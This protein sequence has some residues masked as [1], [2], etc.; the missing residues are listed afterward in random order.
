MDNKNET[1]N[2]TNNEV[3][4]V[5]SKVETPQV[6]TSA[7]ANVV[8]STPQENSKPQVVDVNNT[9]EV[10]QKKVEVNAQNNGGNGNAN[11][12]P[13]SVKPEKGKKDDKKSGHPVFLVL[14]MIFLFAFVYFL[15][16]ITNYVTNYMNEKNG[17]NELKSGTMT[18]TYSDSTDNIDYNYELTLTYEKNRLKRSRMVTT[19][20]LSDTATDSN[21]LTEREN[22]CEFLRTVL[23]ENDIG[24][25][26]SCSISAAVQ[27]TTQTIDYNTLN[28]D[29]I[30]NNIAEFEGFYPEYELNES[31]TEIGNE[32]E[33][34]G[35]NCERNER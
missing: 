16:E 5:T 27:V 19:N 9:N 23:E 2:S 29:F 3:K 28:M 34:N 11:T 20:R 24:M 30:T 25:T 8:N 32:L 12:V 31:V 7:S 4:E 6:I 33:S 21:V 18:C 1:N 15:P 17:T 14:L 22:S 35:Y 13:T 26:A 10:E